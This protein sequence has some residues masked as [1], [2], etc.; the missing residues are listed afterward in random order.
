M[1]LIKKIK[2]IFEKYNNFFPPV[3]KKNGEKNKIIIALSGG[4][5]SSVSLAILKKKGYDVKGVYFKTYKPDGDRTH[6]K[7]EGGDAKKICEFLDVQFEAFDLQKEYKEKVFE[8]M[9]SE[10]K[11]GNTP[12]PDI[13][14]NKYIKF[15]VFLEKAMEIGGDYIATGHYA[16][17]FRSNENDYLTKAE[18]Q[19]KDQTYFLSQI[20]G[21]AL[22]RTIFP[23]GGLNKSVVRK[24]AESFGL[25]TA[26]KKDS[27][28]IC[29]IQKEVNLRDFLE[30]YIEKKE[31]DILNTKG[32]VIGKH[33]SSLFY[34][35]GQRHG[36]EISPK[37]KTP[38]QEKL[39]VINKDFKNNTITIGN[40]DEL[41]NSKNSYKKEIVISEINLFNNNNLNK[42]KGLSG[43]IRHRGEL[44]KINKIMKLDDDKFNVIFDK[45]QKSVAPGQF[46][47][48]Y[49]K[50][51][52]LGS[53]V[54]L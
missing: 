9:V 30:N 27:Q 47:A 50:D 39:F 49:K 34:T 26:E 33:D 51:V 36:F 21:K 44:I 25:F 42:E 48:I 31:G 6:C 3:Y 46:L 22:K 20:S 15:G 17:H 7:K 52:C 11:K 45:E 38:N 13:Y 24:K 4:V 16:K 23:I 1:F 28:G 19:N 40:K 8:Y 37:F 12:N 5:D 29:F 53:G 41:K 43:R 10:Y 32:D 54:I 14:C 35:I 2:K 18:D